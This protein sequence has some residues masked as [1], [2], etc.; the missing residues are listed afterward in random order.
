M[1]I[2]LFLAGLLLLSASVVSAQVVE[3]QLAQHIVTTTMSTHPE[4]QKMGIHVIPPGQQDEIIVACSVPSKIGKK[5]SAND[6]AVKQSG[7]PGVKTVEQGSFYDLALSLNDAQKRPIGLLVMEM[8]FSGAS[9]P[10]DAINKAETIRDGIGEQIPAMAALFNKAPASDPLVL[11][12]TTKLP[13]ISG[14]FDHLSVDLEHNRLYASAEEHHSIE[15]FDLKTGAHIRSAPVATTPHTLAFVSKSGKLLVADGGDSSCRI[16]DAQDLHEVKRIPL[17]AGPD[18]GLYDSQNN[19]FYVGNGGREAKTDYSFIS[20][21]SPEQEK[22]ISRIR[23]ESANLE[24]MALDPD[25]NLLYVNLRDKAQ[26]GVVDLNKR[27]VRQVWSV[28]GLHLN[29][30]MAF[31]KIHHRLF[32]AGRQPGKFSVI[33]SENG[34]LITSLDC[35]ERA[36]DMTFEPAE[37]RIYITGAGGVTV[38]R[39]DGP[40]QY[41]VLTQFA[42]N[43]GKTSVLVPSL[44]QFYI[45]HTKTPEDVA[46]LQVYRIN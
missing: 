2:H 4:L 16:L 45:I 39:Q 13:D 38:V 20:I 41:R 5:S 36:D 26:I 33:N 34:Q 42:T 22:E 9:S 37:K 30:A 23:M 11:L 6:L 21:I 35:V 18:A 40:D 10:S 43:S 15:V 24:A 17:E 8:R 12:S 46:A 3:A 1:K 29:T 14:D 44:K 31:D 27:E 25:A 7:K 28:P 19:L 32:V